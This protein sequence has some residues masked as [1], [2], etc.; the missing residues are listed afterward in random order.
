[1]CQI[2]CHPSA[3]CRRSRPDIHEEAE[4]FSLQFVQIEP[5]GK[6]D[7]HGQVGV[8]RVL[9]GAE[10]LGV[11]VEPFLDAAL[12]AEPRW[13]MMRIIGREARHR[14]YTQDARGFV[15]CASVKI[16]FGETAHQAISPEEQSQ[17]L[18]YGGLATVIRPHQHGV[19][20]Q[21][22]VRRSH[23]PEAGDFQADNVHRVFPPYLVLRHKRPERPAR[24]RTITVLIILAVD[25]FGF[26]DSVMPRHLPLHRQS[27]L[28]SSQHPDGG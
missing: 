3:A 2:P 20:A 22:D 28:E 19:A 13:M 12:G 9:R 14:G 6:T 11:R 17:R 5:R 23:S 27:L 7:L 16:V 8:L 25:R 1:M 4:R 26:A 10:G 18:N 15:R 24:P 21:R